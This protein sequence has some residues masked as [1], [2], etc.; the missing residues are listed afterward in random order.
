MKDKSFWKK[1]FSV[2][3]PLMITTNEFRA[4]LEKYQDNIDTV[5]FS[6]P[7]GER[8]HARERVVEQLK[9]R[10]KVELLWELAAIVKEYNINL[11]V[12]FNT[13]KLIPGD[14]EDCRKL[15]DKH[16][17]QV[18]KVAVLDSIDWY[19]NS[20]KEFFPEAA[21]VQSVNDMKNTPEGLRTYKHKYEEIIVGRHLIR[22]VEAA[23]TVKELGSKCVLLLNNG[24]SFICGGCREKAYC[25]RMYDKAR[26][27]HSAEY[28]YALQSIMPFELHDEYFP[29]EYYDYFK[30][31][32]RNGDGDYINQ[33][34]DSY[35]NN[36]TEEYIAQGSKYYHLWGKLTWHIPYYNVFD[37]N[38][39]KEIKKQICNY[40][41][42]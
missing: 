11:E 25:K 26:E 28:L 1:R 34:L 16:H 35:I 27:S 24:C 7:M 18:D 19:Y 13:F 8:F 38:R 10:E 3:M 41:D 14:I 20:V 5:Y 17:I 42:S 30:L 12:V 9:S 21:V 22:N 23:R 33:T 6:P 15:F 37:L 39:I 29:L 36:K 32:T 31:A 4:C 2:G 40:P